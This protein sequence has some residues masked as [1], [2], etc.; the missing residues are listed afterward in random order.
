M[1]VERADTAIRNSS[2][3]KVRTDSVELQESL[4]LI[5]SSLAVGLRAF[6]SAERIGKIIHSSFPSDLPRDTYTQSLLK[7]SCR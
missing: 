4:S 3:V 5:S 1:L 7:R 6:V 2:Q